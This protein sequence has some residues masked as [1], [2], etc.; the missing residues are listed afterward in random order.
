MLTDSLARLDELGVDVIVKTKWH[1][2]GILS[3]TQHRPK[4]LAWQL[5]CQAEVHKEFTQHI[6]AWLRNQ[7]SLVH[8][9]EHRRIAFVRQ[10]EAAKVVATQPAAGG[11]IIN[12]SPY[13]IPT[14]K[15]AYTESEGLIY[16]PAQ[17]SDDAAM[18]PP[19]PLKPD[20]LLPLDATVVA[21]LEEAVAALSLDPTGQPESDDEADS[22][23]A[24]S[25]P[26]PAVASAAPV[27]TAATNDSVSVGDKLRLTIALTADGL[28]VR[29]VR[30]LLSDHVGGC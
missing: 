18:I 3:S 2:D 25:P 12:R 27:S 1:P 21:E 5:D 11:S 22:G 4:T 14:L 13:V 28:K 15:M 16:L 20:A 26:A 7:H 17:R 29:A 8:A 30:R 9:R 19:F 24:A 23:D 6:G 10:F